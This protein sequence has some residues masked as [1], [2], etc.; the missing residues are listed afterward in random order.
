MYCPPQDANLQVAL[1]LSST[2]RAVFETDFDNGA[3]T[4]V[5]ARA[6]TNVLPACG[7]KQED[8]GR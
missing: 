7:A 4:D 3:E 1:S 5:T 6:E 8:A 2:R